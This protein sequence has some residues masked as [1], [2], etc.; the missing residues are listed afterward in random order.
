MKKMAGLL[1]L[2]MIVFLSLR[3]YGANSMPYDPCAGQPRELCSST[4]SVNITATGSWD[5]PFQ[6]LWDTLTTVGNFAIDVFTSP[7]E[8]VGHAINGEWGEAFTDLFF[9]DA[10][11]GFV[12]GMGNAIENFDTFKLSMDNGFMSGGFGLSAGIDVSM[13][14]TSHYKS[15]EI[16][17]YYET[18]TKCVH[19]PTADNPFKQTCTTER[20]P[21][22]LEQMIQENATRKAYVE[23]AIYCNGIDLDTCFI[24]AE[25]KLV[26]W[27]KDKADFF[28]LAPGENKE[29]LTDFI[30]Q[31]I[32]LQQDYLNDID[33]K[34]QTLK[35]MEQTEDRKELIAYW[36]KRK[37]AGIENIV[38]LK[39]AN[40]PI[41]PTGPI[42]DPKAPQ[43]Q[44]KCA[45]D[46]AKQYAIAIGFKDEDFSQTVQKDSSGNIILNAT[47]Q[48]KPI[49]FPAWIVTGF[50]NT[51]TDDQGTVTTKQ[52]AYPENPLS[53]PRELDANRL[54]AVREAQQ[55]T[56]LNEM[57]TI[58]QKTEATMPGSTPGSEQKIWTTYLGTN[59]QY[60]IT[61]PYGNGTVNRNK[62]AITFTEQEQAAMPEDE[63]MKMVVY[64]IDRKQERTTSSNQFFLNKT[65]FYTNKSPVTENI[66]FTAFPTGTPSNTGCQPVS[67]YESEKVK[68]YPQQNSKYIYD[69]EKPASP[70]E[71]LQQLQ[72]IENYLH[73][74]LAYRDQ[75][76]AAINSQIAAKGGDYKVNDGAQWLYAFNMMA[77]MKFDM[78]EK[79]FSPEEWKKRNLMSMQGVESLTE[80]NIPAMLEEY[81]Q[82]ES[83][84][85]REA[86]RQAADLKYIEK[87]LSEDNLTPEQRGI[88]LQMRSE[89]VTRAVKISEM[90]VS[91]GR[92]LAFLNQ[93]AFVQSLLNDYQA[94]NLDEIERKIAENL[95]DE[96]KKIGVTT[97]LVLPTAKTIDDIKK[98]EEQ[99][100]KI[101]SDIALRLKS[102]YASLSNSSTGYDYLLALSSDDNTVDTLLYQK[103]VLEQRISA[104][105]KDAQAF[106]EVRI[107]F[108]YT[109]KDGTILKLERTEKIALEEWSPDFAID[110]NT[111]YN[112]GGDDFVTVMKGKAQYNA[113]GTVTVK[114]L[115]FRND[116]MDANYRQ[117]AMLQ[118]QAK[119]AISFYEKQE[120]EAQA[121]ALILEARQPGEKSVTFTSGEYKYYR[122]E[123]EAKEIYNTLGQ[124]KA[125]LNQLEEQ[126]LKLSS[127]PVLFL[128]NAG[129]IESINL[130]IQTLRK[131]I[132][133]LQAAYNEKSGLNQLIAEIQKAVYQKMNFVQYPGEDSPIN[134]SEK[135]KYLVYTE[136]IYDFSGPIAQNTGQTVTKYVLKAEYMH[137]LFKEQTLPNGKKTSELQKIVA[138]IASKDT[139]L[140]LVISRSWN[141]ENPM[142][143]ADYL[144][145]KLNEYFK[146]HAAI[147]GKMDD[148]FFQEKFGISKDYAFTVLKPMYEGFDTFAK[149][150]MFSSF[151]S[152]I[153]EMAM[154][155]SDRIMQISNW[156]TNTTRL[157]PS[158]QMRLVGYSPTPATDQLV[159][160]GQGLVQVVTN[161][162]EAVA[163]LG[164]S[165]STGILNG[166]IGLASLADVISNAYADF[167][168][169]PTGES[170]ADNMRAFLG[171]KDGGF[172]SMPSIPREFLNGVSKTLEGGMFVLEFAAWTKLISVAQ[173]IGVKALFHGG[174]QA[175]QY[176]TSLQTRTFTEKLIFQAAD[177]FAV[178]TAVGNILKDQTKRFVANLARSGLDYACDIARKASADGKLYLQVTNEAGQVIFKEVVTD[179]DKWA[180]VKQSTAAM[181]NFMKATSNSFKNTGI[182]FIPYA[183]I[184]S[185]WFDAGTGSFKW[186]EEGIDNAL[187]KTQKVREIMDETLASNG[188][189]TQFSTDYNKWKFITENE[190]LL[191]SFN[192]GL[193]KANLF[194]NVGPWKDWYTSMPDL[195]SADGKIVR[196][197]DG[198]EDDFFEAAGQLIAEKVDSF[199]TYFPE[200]LLKPVLTHS[201][202]V[203]KQTLI[204]IFDATGRKIDDVFQALAENRILYNA[205]GEVVSG[206]QRGKLADTL[207]ENTDETIY[208]LDE[209]TGQVMK[210]DRIK[211][212]VLAIDDSISVQYL[213]AD[214][215]MI[216]TEADGS[217]KTIEKKLTE[218]ELADTKAY[219]SRQYMEKTLKDKQAIEAMINQ[220]PEALNKL[221]IAEQMKQI[222][223]AQTSLYWTLHE[224][225][226][227]AQVEIGLMD[228][229][230]K[231]QASLEGLN[232]IESFKQGFSSPIAA[233]DLFPY[234]TNLKYLEETRAA[235]LEAG[236]STTSIDQ[237]LILA[238]NQFKNGQRIQEIQTLFLHG[239]GTADLFNE[240]KSLLSNMENPVNSYEIYLKNQ[241]ASNIDLT[242]KLDAL[243]A[244]YNTANPIRQEEIL[245]EMRREFYLFSKNG[246][247]FTEPTLVG[248]RTQDLTNKISYLESLKQSKEIQAASLESTLNQ[249]SDHFQE[250]SPLATTN[251][252]PSLENALQF[253]N[254]RFDE[255]TRYQDL[256]LQG[257]TKDFTEES[258]EVWKKEIQYFYKPIED[259]SYAEFMADNQAL[260]NMTIHVR[261]FDSITTKKIRTIE[262]HQKIINQWNEIR[263]KNPADV[264]MQDFENIKAAVKYLKAENYYP[265]TLRREIINLK[266][267][268]HPYEPVEVGKLDLIKMANEIEV[269]KRRIDYLEAFADNAAINEAKVELYYWEKE[270]A[271]YQQNPDKLDIVVPVIFQEPTLTDLK[272][273]LANQMSEELKNG[274]ISLGIDPTAADLKTLAYLQRQLGYAQKN[275]TE[276]SQEI[277]D[278]LTQQPLRESVENFLTK[279]KMGVANEADFQ[280]FQQAVNALSDTK[281]SNYAPFGDDILALKSD[282]AACNSF[283]EFKAFF[284]NLSNGL[285]TELN[286]KIISLNQAL[287]NLTLTNP[288]FIKQLDANLVTAKQQIEQLS[289]FEEFINLQ[290]LTDAQLLTQYEKIADLYK[291]ILNKNLGTD[292]AEIKQ[293]IF[294]MDSYLKKAYPDQDAITILMQ[295]AS[296][297]YDLIQSQEAVYL[298][299]FQKET[300]ELINL[301]NQAK[302]TEE[303]AAIKKQ[304]EKLFIDAGLEDVPP[305]SFWQEKSIEQLTIEKIYTLKK[306]LESNTL[307]TEKQPGIAN[308]VFDNMLADMGYSWKESISTHPVYGEQKTINLVKEYLDETTGTVRRSDVQL[309]DTKNG[310]LL[311][312]HYDNL[313]T[314]APVTENG[315]KAMVQQ[316]QLTTDQQIIAL[317]TKTDAY[318][319]AYQR[320]YTQ[321]EVGEKAY[322]WLLEKEAG[323]LSAK[324]LE[325][326]KEIF[327][328]YG[329]TFNYATLND[330]LKEQYFKSLG[331]LT[332]AKASGNITEETF[333]A[334]MIGIDEAFSLRSGFDVVYSD[335]KRIFVKEVYEQVSEN[336]AIK[337][338]FRQTYLMND[339]SIIETIGNRPVTIKGMEDWLAQAKGFQGEIDMKVMMETL[340]HQIADPVELKI[341]CENLL[342]QIGKVNKQA[343]FLSY[344]YLDE[345]FMVVN[346]YYNPVH[347]VLG[348]VSNVFYAGK[349]ISP[350]LFIGNTTDNFVNFMA[351]TLNHSVARVIEKTGLGSHISEAIT[352]GTM[353]SSDELKEMARGF[354]DVFSN[355]TGKVDDVTSKYAPSMAAS[356]IE[357]LNFLQRVGKTCVADDP[358]IRPYALRQSNDILTYL[359]SKELLNGAEQAAKEMLEQATKAPEGVLRYL[360]NAL[361]EMQ[362]SETKVILEEFYISIFDYSAKNALTNQNILVNLG[363]RIQDAANFGLPFGLGTVI[364]PFYK[365]TTNFGIRMI[366]YTPLAFGK[367]VRKL[368]KSY[369]PTVFAGMSDFKKAQWKKQFIEEFAQGIV[370]TGVTATMVALLYFDVISIDKMGNVIMNV[371]QLFSL[372]FGE[373]KPIE[374]GDVTIT[375]DNGIIGRIGSSIAQSHIEGKEALTEGEYTEY[376]FS[377]LQNLTT[378]ATDPTYIGKLSKLLGINLSTTESKQTLMQKAIVALA[379]IPASMIP[380]LL[381]DI[382]NMNDQYLRAVYSE[383]F[384]DMM[385]N[386][387]QNS[388]PGFSEELQ[389]LT[390][391]YGNP[392]KRSSL[393]GWAYVISPVSVFIVEGD[394][395]AIQQVDFVVRTGFTEI[396]TPRIQDNPNIFS[397]KK[398]A[399]DGSEYTAYY[400]EAVV[401]GKTIQVYITAKEKEAFSDAFN[402]KYLDLSQ[403]II[404]NEYLS[405]EEKKQQL[406]AA[407]KEATISA[408]NDLLTTRRLDE[409]YQKPTLAQSVLFR[410]M[411]NDDYI[412]YKEIIVNMRENELAG[413]PVNPQEYLEKIYDFYEEKYLENPTATMFKEMAY[414]ASTVDNYTDFYAKLL[415]IEQRNTVTEGG[416]I[417]VVLSNSNDV[418]QYIQE[419]TQIG[420]IERYLMGTVY[421]QL[422]A[423]EKAKTPQTNELTQQYENMIAQKVFD[424][425]QTMAKEYHTD[426][427]NAELQTDEYVSSEEI[428][429]LLN[430]TM[431][432]LQ[433]NSV[434]NPYGINTSV[435]NPA[436]NAFYT[437]HSYS[438][439]SQFSGSSTDW[440]KQILNTP[441]K[442]PNQPTY[443]P[444]N[445]FSPY[446]S[447]K[448]VLQIAQS[449]PT[450]TYFSGA[451]VNESQM[452]ATLNPVM[453]RHL[454]LSELKKA[455]TSIDLALYGITSAGAWKELLDVLKERAASGVQIRIVTDEK[456]YWASLEQM[457]AL[458]NISATFSN[459]DVSM[460]NSSAIMHNKYFIIDNKAVITGSMNI[461]H[462]SLRIGDPQKV[463]DNFITLKG[464]AAPTIETPPAPYFNATAKTVIFGKTNPLTVPA[465]NVFEIDLTQYISVTQF[466]TN[467]GAYIV[468]SKDNINFSI[469]TPYLTAE[470]RVVV[471][472]LYHPTETGNH[473]T[474][475]SIIKIND[476]KDNAGNV[477]YNGHIN[478]TF[479]FRNEE[480]AM[481]YTSDFLNMYK[482]GMNVYGSKKISAG[483]IAKAKTW[484][485]DPTQTYSLGG[486]PFMTFFTPYNTS[487]PKKEYYID[488][489]DKIYI[490]DGK[491]TDGEQKG[492]ALNL[493]IDMVK[494]ANKIR[495]YGYAVSDPILLHTL[496]KMEKPLKDIKVYIENDQ[497]NALNED[498]KAR[499]QLLNMKH[500]VYLHNHKSS[501][502]HIKTI[503]LDDNIVISGSLNF[504]RNATTRNDEN[505]FIISNADVA[506]LFNRFENL[507]N[508]GKFSYP[509]ENSGATSGLNEYHYINRMS[510]MPPQAYLDKVNAANTIVAIHLKARNLQEQIDLKTQHPTFQETASK[511]FLVD[512]AFELL[513]DATD[514]LDSAYLKRISDGKRFFIRWTGYL[515]FQ[516]TEIFDTPENTPITTTP[517]DPATDPENTITGIA[518]KN[519]LSS[520]HDWVVVHKDFY[521]GTM[522]DEL[523]TLYTNFVNENAAIVE[524]ESGFFGSIISVKTDYIQKDIAIKKESPWIKIGAIAGGVVLIAAVGAATF[525]SGG[526]FAGIGAV[527]VESIIGSV[528][529][530]WML[531]G[532]IVGG[533]IGGNLG[534]MYYQKEWKE[535][536]KIY[537]YYTKQHIQDWVKYQDRQAHWDKLTQTLFSGEKRKGANSKGLTPFVYLETGKTPVFVPE[538]TI[539]NDPTRGTIRKCFEY[540]N[541]WIDETDFA[542]MPD[543][544]KDGKLIQWT[545]VDVNTPLSIM[546]ENYGQ[547]GWTTKPHVENY[548]RAGL[549]LYYWSGSPTGWA[550]RLNPDDWE[551]IKTY[552]AYLKIEPNDQNWVYTNLEETQ[553]YLQSLNYTKIRQSSLQSDLSNK[554]KPVLII[555][556]NTVNDTN[557]YY[558]VK[559]FLNRGGYFLKPKKRNAKIEYIRTVSAKTKCNVVLDCTTY[560]RVGSWVHFAGYNGKIKMTTTLNTLHMPNSIYDNPATN[561]YIVK[562]GWIYQPGANDTLGQL[563]QSKFGTMIHY[564]T[565]EEEYLHPTTKLGRLKPKK[566]EYIFNAVISKAH[567]ETLTPEQ[568]SYYGYLD[569]ENQPE[570]VQALLLANL[571]PKKIRILPGFTITKWQ[572]EGKTIKDLKVSY[573]EAGLIELPTNHDK[574]GE[575]GND[576]PALN[577]NPAYLY[578]NQKAAVINWIK[579]AQVNI[580]IATTALDDPEI[581]SALQEQ[582][583]KGVLVSVISNKK[584]NY[585]DAIGVIDHRFNSTFTGNLMMIDG[586]F[587][588]WKTGDFKTFANYDFTSIQKYT[589]GNLFF[590]IALME[591][592]FYHNTS[593]EGQPTPTFS[594]QKTFIPAY[595][596]NG[597][598]LPIAQTEQTMIWPLPYAGQQWY[599]GA[600]NKTI[601]RTFDI[602][603]KCKSSIMTQYSN[604]LLNVDSILTSLNASYQTIYTSGYIIANQINDPLLITS[605]NKK[606][607][608]KAYVDK[609]FYNSLTGTIGTMAAKTYISYGLKPNSINTL[610][611]IP[612][613]ILY[614]RS[615]I[616]GVPDRVIFSSVGFVTSHWSINDGYVIDSTDIKVTQEFK[617]MINEI[618]TTP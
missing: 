511:A 544:C 449:D 543:Y 30:E 245:Q 406:L 61:E 184:R 206:I 40:T 4:G 392:I 433:T 368:A 442:V 75:E 350:T 310:I 553:N 322:M 53:T 173:Q 516:N 155:F 616:T 77:K 583:S 240:L 584:L 527:V 247:E 271:Y 366:E 378:H 23:K 440:V 41:C 475:L 517:T 239:Q 165:I 409:S 320:V 134:E 161:L 459:V 43:T 11:M 445:V 615:T 420:Q 446:D 58:Q 428:R 257:Q 188:I 318:N 60:Y 71:E 56:A 91:L 200:H 202:T 365:V 224:T 489:E 191:E 2:L 204:E 66:A 333:H 580:S 506:M 268:F 504:S 258:F 219:L 411:S 296:L 284:S 536:G 95:T 264:T 575:I 572:I 373:K 196:M 607:N 105:K 261:Y 34:L 28:A 85:K 302:S 533:V 174:P 6:F 334:A 81:S 103:I 68:T 176:A 278:L 538:T 386:K 162:P 540:H 555:I 425:I 87:L 438:N 132:P 574:I 453:A 246:L 197:I 590:M 185:N 360:E 52:I 570:L 59:Y 76:I 355:L 379:G 38:N 510:Q 476:Y 413:K 473:A 175:A 216:I 344:E 36:E 158:E 557:A 116:L 419:R 291:S 561:G 121:Q 551:E 156:A 495:V 600:Q 405:D 598:P 195:F 274:L 421:N 289:S 465:V 113:D 408:M 349:L 430:Q 147:T 125:A 550:I 164:D 356:D 363:K 507:M 177:F 407:Q 233:F 418:G 203:V 474:S 343:Q 83:S 64:I 485:S 73:Q 542:T 44:I 502:F 387:I 101:T 198:F 260:Y 46:P 522:S 477:I 187:A 304:M 139:Y 285:E 443:Y 436:P 15:E 232:S 209:A 135:H 276:L 335:G 526:T 114:Y 137:E 466:Q 145:D 610:K 448:W 566:A 168:G 279:L 330:A 86:D 423:E 535:S 381:K 391:Q 99:L 45:P 221:V 397:V 179:K 613:N 123:N 104:I 509:F 309:I 586:M 347:A 451:G 287:D 281:I 129:Q 454:L 531:G 13:K 54:Q 385:V 398:L 478:N 150:P 89:L 528:G 10:I 486:I 588:I 84:I 90:D 313:M 243:K 364:M 371:S 69:W 151:T 109:A 317:S 21:V 493:V 534:N 97:R 62:L 96:Q 578:G 14:K 111:V 214:G 314:G 562:D 295:K 464:E 548:T 582:I 236:K 49:Q 595:Q 456:A 596:E 601:C 35:N 217:V 571:D 118:A 182:S 9:N 186:L 537:K 242:A 127:D 222:D 115:G 340:S 380:T 208:I 107:P 120:L 275:T 328:K 20:S 498:S 346:P 171:V 220:D 345:V 388:L 472:A 251:L 325:R 447:E 594:N 376:V 303:I 608:I 63:R 331:L 55:C 326:I 336:L 525:F 50:S 254:Q 144:N 497:F 455:Q 26:Q 241:I 422:I 324:D 163:F 603:G 339:G 399:S 530:G 136:P 306:R 280:D 74:R 479:V 152:V 142:N 480:V 65:I 228:A 19:T 262:L 563:F 37:E 559:D 487:Y 499:M 556:E 374:A 253:Q 117:A 138:N 88:L 79:E 143:S 218:S 7:F 244:E 160:L 337:H 468:N 382:R 57:K 501:L 494:R 33:Q 492:N 48:G 444:G 27:E 592:F 427:E 394:E 462:N 341:A 106:V 458:D 591:L 560:H 547:T 471:S 435:S 128:Q 568:Q 529:V 614:L 389:V 178:D 481:A 18:Y 167:M 201:D 354:G 357:I 307:L 267:F 235:F 441:P 383:N 298:E 25:A 483:W 92:Q 273:M 78:F 223:S 183:K 569:F 424:R 518:L 149:L 564:S 146:A 431:Q 98:L 375:F 585:L 369:D 94:Q 434:S 609:N 579:A 133:T 500:P 482:D 211:S 67:V 256:F 193:A 321:C 611:N 416:T 234:Q 581:L 301:L 412:I 250:H 189:T 141:P 249:L 452:I 130:K 519:Y 589:D 593:E 521:N 358:V 384:F 605:I 467:P 573:A 604:R 72:I 554:E 288:D 587:L 255:L 312:S 190:A 460:G 463:V 207:L 292:I 231:A 361:K 230:K 432:T 618:I 577:P 484:M 194:E 237:A 532:A 269:M 170:L 546:L 417:K 181:D 351:N 51:V 332:L 17:R 488:W 597:K 272:N 82:L 265:E 12:D 5:S 157:L 545:G 539:I 180:F 42:S 259:I 359:K 404:S 299:M 520:M 541:K 429:V 329:E 315:V 126:A 490:Y 205:A 112:K 390:D 270:F 192:S 300:Q 602:T 154:F 342:A 401:G 80:V 213:E 1:I 282:I 352:L 140:A 252:A 552:E 469:S 311:S 199:V 3:I 414:A 225:Q 617:K 148:F 503:I 215:L 172:I 450:Y 612:Y 316:F 210:I 457:N 514:N 226:K 131:E 100:Q 16:N 286:L 565:K 153:T 470:G 599:A 523:Q 353:H 439:P 70:E 323:N 124:K 393:E 558:Q 370:G 229:I 512:P 396:V 362:M 426:W 515:G 400:T 410:D 169:I 606:P 227:A 505:F 348:E 293:A 212:Q 166:S 102:D 308:E 338:Q 290:N 576:Y 294:E 549:P 377:I 248:I 159:T 372:F 29:E 513:A 415:E 122:T 31:M 297:N 437:Q 108:L 39:L 266:Q 319:A 508:T 263:L 47:G 395:R 491:T 567:Y 524:S 461:S 402:E 283:D 496:F 238:K 22:Q 119:N 24:E 93:K 327:A 367:F 32:F 277:A 305:S 110:Q 403:A 8:A